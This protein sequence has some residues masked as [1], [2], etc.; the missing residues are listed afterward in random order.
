MLRLRTASTNTGNPWL[1]LCPPCS[2][3]STDFSAFLFYYQIHRWRGLETPLETISNSAALIHADCPCSCSPGR[4]TRPHTSTRLYIAHVC[5]SWLSSQFLFCLLYLF[6]LYEYLP[7]VL[8][9]HTSYEYE[10][11]QTP[12]SI[13]HHKRATEARD[14]TKPLLF[15]ASTSLPSF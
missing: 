1:A 10:I 5:C 7:P 2:F 8:L 11:L 3:S 6:C 15:S 9:R 13:F 14:L 12:D 4:T